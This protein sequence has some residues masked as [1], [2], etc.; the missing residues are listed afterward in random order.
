MLRI[1]VHEKPGA[2]ELRLEGR[3]AGPWVQV[4]EECWQTAISQLRE[5]ALCVDLT[6]VTSMDAEGQAKLNAM[7][8]QRVAIVAADGLMKSIVAEIIGERSGADRLA[9]RGPPIDG[10]VINPVHHVSDQ[11]STYMGEQ[12]HE[13]HPILNQPD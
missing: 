4:L 3:L 5:R 2:L 8:R 6:G 12:G 10:T 9:A 1:T 7:H 11:D 13:R